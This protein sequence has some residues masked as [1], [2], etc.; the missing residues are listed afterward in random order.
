MAKSEL[1]DDNPSQAAFIER[2]YRDTYDLLVELRDYLEE[3]PA[4]DAGTLAPDDRLQ[5][6]YELSVITRQLTNVMAWLMLRRAVIAGEIS[7]DQAAS[8]PA[9]ALDILSDDEA[10]DDPA[11]RARLPIAARGLLDRAQRLVAHVGVLAGG[12]C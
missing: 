9:A 12:R 6:T 4:S 8:D 7:E 10:Q 1:M 2:A 5:L 11:A 3:G